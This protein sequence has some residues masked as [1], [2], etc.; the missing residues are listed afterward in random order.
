[1]A[2]DKKISA[3]TTLSTPADNDYMP[4]VDVSE[5]AD[6]D[7]NKKILISGLKT[8]LG[9]VVGPSSSTNNA[10]ARWDTTTGKLLQDSSVTIDDNGSIN[11]PSG[12]TYDIN[13]TA[14]TY[15]DVAA[16]PTT[17][18]SQHESGGADDI[19]LDDL[20][21]PSDN[22]DLDVSGSAHGLTP[23]LPAANPTLKFFRGDGTY[24]APTGV[25]FG[26]DGTDGD[27]G[28]AAET[29]TGSNNT[30]IVKNYS[31]WTAGSVARTCTIT[32]TGCV[33]H[34]KIQGDA[35]FTNWTFDFD[36]KGV[37]GAAG[38]A[39]G[40]GTGAGA[41]GT[42]GNTSAINFFDGE[43]AAGDGKGGT[44]N[45]V[46]PGGGGGAGAASISGAGDAGNIG[47]T[48]GGG[49]PGD[50]G[51]A[52]ANSMSIQTFATLPAMKKLMY[53][54]GSG[55]AGGGGGA[56]GSNG[57]DNGGAGG[58][59]GAGG[60]ALIIEVG[61]ALTLSSTT[62]T[63]NGADGTAGSVPAG[64]T[65]GG[66]GG[67]GGGSGGTCILIYDSVSGSVTPTVAKGSAGA[68]GVSAGYNGGAGGDGANGLYLVTENV[69][70]A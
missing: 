58:A 39:G 46:G 32:P 56:Y 3:L 53:F 60:G 36:G 17:H 30:Y 2:T 57:P 51:S 64:V 14:I 8:E 7:K 11:I 42:D 23:K 24:A 62:I 63:C 15:T 66:G 6:A 68:G 52:S 25:K 12:E 27:P 69:D 21:A 10:I 44:D 59:G 13:G 67:G 22:T 49:T 18:A 31:S 35:D 45:P 19:Q 61:G 41:D 50:G 34:I 29:I 40:T 33:C 1:M 5:S 43:T 37:A 47:I 55:G 38:G 70:F 65:G 20:A 4:I 54:V 28:D 26:G 48:G 16:S 9:D